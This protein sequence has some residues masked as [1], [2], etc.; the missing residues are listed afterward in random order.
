MVNPDLAL[1]PT[2]AAHCSECAFRPPCLALQQGA[3]AE[4][5]LAAG[6][7]TRPP[8][9]PEEGRLGGVT[10]SMNRGAVP[11]PRWRGRNP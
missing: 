7:R 11:P 3:D 1:Y 5:I 4:A 10:W 9:A 6:Y 2:P 8:E